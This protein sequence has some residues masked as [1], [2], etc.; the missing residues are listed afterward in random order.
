MR[1]L[2][3]AFSQVHETEMYET[4]ICEAKC[5]GFATI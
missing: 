1:S 2:V 4:E 3:D 5:G